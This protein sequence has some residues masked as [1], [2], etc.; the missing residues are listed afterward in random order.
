LTLIELSNQAGTSWNR[1]IESQ[2]SDQKVQDIQE[3]AANLKKHLKKP[4]LSWFDSST[5]YGLRWLNGTLVA[6]EIIEYLFHT[7]VHSF[8]AE[9]DPSVSKILTLFDRHSSGNFARALFKGWTGQN[10]TQKET[11]CFLVSVLLGDD[12][13]AKPLR[14]EIDYWTRKNRKPL[15]AFG[16]EMLGRLGSELSTAEL[17]D[18]SDKNKSPKIRE[19]ASQVLD[20]IAASRGISRQDLTDRILP[21]LGFDERAERR[22]D[23]GTR[24]FI[25]RLTPGMIISLEDSQGKILKDLLP[26]PGG[27]DDQS[28]SK[29]ASAE[30][31]ALKSQNRDA[32]TRIMRRLDKALAE[33][34]SWTKSD[35][36]LLFQNHPVGR[37]IATTLVWGIT[38]LQGRYTRLFRP[39]EEGTFSDEVDQNVDPGDPRPATFVNKNGER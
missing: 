14:T 7:Q 29:I 38:S 37:S 15:A 26:K 1:I 18:L 24:H 34:Q 27:N 20:R 11:W 22:F 32:V 16:V 19:V 39:L 17:D 23:F 21:R 10:S 5:N 28:K 6:P 3:R 35:W 13:L 33:Q 36:I 30:W 31:K 25:A 9:L 8:S 12:Q 2:Y 4:V